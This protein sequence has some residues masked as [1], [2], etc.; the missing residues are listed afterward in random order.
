MNINDKKTVLLDND[1]KEHDIAWLIRKK[2]GINRELSNPIEPLSEEQIAVLEVKRDNIQY[3]INNAK[4]MGA[5][6]D[7]WELKLNA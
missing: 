6:V 5:K 7:E 1:S 4:F 3:F 2:I